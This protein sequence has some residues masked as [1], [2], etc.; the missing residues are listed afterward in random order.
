M[1]MGL[2]NK[3]LFD[4]LTEQQQN[5][6]LEKA[7]GHRTENGT[8]EYYSTE[9]L[10]NTVEALSRG[11]IQL[12]LK[13]GD[14]VATVIYKSI[15]EWVALDFA[16]LR[17]GIINVPLYPTISTREYAY[18]LNEAEVKICFV[19]D[20]DLFDK[21]NAAR[22]EA[23]GVQQ[24]YS[25]FE[26]PEAVSWRDLLAPP[27][28]ELDETI[29]QISEKIQP[30]DV[31]TIIY[32]SGTTGNPKGVVLTH[33]NIVFNVE[34]MRVLLPISPG[35]SG[36][37]FLPVSHIFERAVVYAYTAYGASVSFTTPDRL[38]GEDGDLQALKPHF[39][40][41]VPRLLEKVY[42]KIYGKGLELKG[43]KR[44]LFF[45]AL[46]MAEQW[47]F[48][49]PFTGFAALKWF[50]FDKLIFAK[51]RAALGGNIKGIVVGASACPM[52]IMR[53]FNAAGILV[54]EGYGMTEAAP[55]VSFN[56]F[57][58]GGAM[59]GCVGQ[60]IA[61]VTVKIEQA[62]E[63]QPGEGEILVKGEGVMV[64]YYKQPEK[65]AE[66][67]RTEGNERWLC[68]GDIGKLV[69]SPQG[70]TFLQITDRKK[71]L[72]KTSNGK[73]VAPSPIESAFKS[74]RLVEQAMVVGDNFKFVSILIV[75]SNDGLK[76]WCQKHQV[77][78]TDMHE[79]IHHPKVQ[80]RYQMLLERVNPAF[81][82][83]EQV[84]KFAL[85]PD[86]WEATRSDGTEAELTPTLKLKRRVIL[87]KFGAEIEEIYAGD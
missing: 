39:F 69:T 56:R 87:K 66:M 6:P 2:T 38:G 48:D 29:A 33:R 26:H 84:R 15:P 43:L 25:F 12:G 36:L 47:D 63:S 62:T 1:V 34:T 49:K 64:G 42:E 44:A 78:W 58:P 7:F 5:M 53:V 57:E 46:E 68:T 9:K 52:H 76:A 14:K 51:W 75:P 16:M 65:T 50:V 22:R 67:I 81:A 8:W 73:Y 41:A 61:G 71:E 60:I 31:A 13:P 59:L 77:P 79:M 3:R 21:V 19:G 72:L 18:I 37:S 74:H 80:E 35:D 11:L 83:F 27:D 70:K 82:Q 30:D 55:A 23:S 45:K 85:I 54:R 4:Y 20:G 86:T 24:I 40:A 17:N 10:V 32:T 28:P